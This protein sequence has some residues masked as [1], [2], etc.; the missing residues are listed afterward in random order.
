MAHNPRFQPRQ[1]FPQPFLLDGDVFGTERSLAAKAMEFAASF[2]E[3]F[4][5]FKEGKVWRTGLGELL[6]IA[7]RACQMRQALLLRACGV[8][9]VARVAIGDQRASKIIT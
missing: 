4:D 2:D 8:C 9:D 6:P 5:R 3:L 1:L 7:R